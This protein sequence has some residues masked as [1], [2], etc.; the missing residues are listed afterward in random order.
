M[1]RSD[2]WF[3]VLAIV[4]ALLVH[5]LVG[6]ERANR[7]VIV[8]ADE[9][10]HAWKLNQATGEVRLLGPWDSTSPAVDEEVRRR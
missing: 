10:G 1:T 2:W 8:R 5:A 6:T 7:W 4:T 3:G 9:A